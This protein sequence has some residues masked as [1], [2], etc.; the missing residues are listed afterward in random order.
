MVVH[1]RQSKG[2]LFFKMPSRHNDPTSFLDSINDHVI[3]FFEVLDSGQI[4]GRFGAASMTIRELR[5]RFPWERGGKG[6]E[7]LIYFI[8]FKYS[9]LEYRFL[10]DETHLLGSSLIMDLC[11]RYENLSRNMAN[12]KGPRKSTHKKR[13][14]N[15]TS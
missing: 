15:K 5:E 9:D 4:T 1:F 3:V 11:V 10:D 13:I 7:N 6:N 8:G 14:S 2:N 12:G